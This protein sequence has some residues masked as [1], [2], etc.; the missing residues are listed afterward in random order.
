ML[1]RRALALG[2]TLKGADSLCHLRT[3]HRDNVSA[4]T[5]DAFLRTH[6]LPNLR[7][8]AISDRPAVR[9]PTDRFQ[10]STSS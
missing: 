3:E 9:T 2:S 4:I 1:K 5:P 8:N 6:S 7:L 10:D